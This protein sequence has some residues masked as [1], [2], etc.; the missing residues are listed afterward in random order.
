MLSLVA[1][2]KTLVKLSLHNAF[3]ASL[4][5]HSEILGKNNFLSFFQKKAYSAF[6]SLLKRSYLWKMRG[7]PQFSF[8]ISIAADMIY[9]SHIVIMWGKKYFP[10]VGTVLKI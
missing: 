10:L 1:C 9:L 8:W 7:Y 3:C 2:F 6:F 4:R 5:V